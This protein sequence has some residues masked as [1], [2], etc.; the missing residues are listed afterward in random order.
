VGKDTVA[1][2]IAQRYRFARLGFADA[3]KAEVATRLPRT[4]AIL[5]EMF[6][7]TSDLA[8]LD[9][10]IETPET[11]LARK[12][13]VVR[14]LL[15]EYGTEVRRTDDPDYWLVQWRRQAQKI[16]APGIV[17]PDVRFPNEERYIKRQG[18]VVLLVTRPGIEFNLNGHI[19]E[20]PLGRPLDAT[21]VNDGGLAQLSR[22]TCAAVDGLTARRAWRKVLHG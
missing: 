9:D 2:I 6:N 14:A 22:N 7:E 18:G 12:P 16:T 15:Q 17:I 19:S 11:L 21:I 8:D 20:V 3:L 13:P 4:L 5:A 1:A 10:P